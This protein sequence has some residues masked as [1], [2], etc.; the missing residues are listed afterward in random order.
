MDYKSYKNHSDIVSTLEIRREN[1]VEILQLYVLL[2]NIDK[3]TFMKYDFQY[4]NFAYSFTVDGHDIIEDDLSF[5]QNRY[6]IILKDRDIIF[7]KIVF[8]KR[9]WYRKI[10]KDL[11]KKANLNLRRI[12]E[13][14]KD[15][16]YQNT[17]LNIFVVSDKSTLK[18]A[19]KLQSN[20]EILLHANIKVIEDIEKIKKTLYLKN[21]KNII[22]YAV[23]DEK[24][25]NETRHI[26]EEFNEFVIVIGPNDHALSLTCGK[27]LI[28]NYVCI[29]TFSPE[30]IKNMVINTKYKLLNKNKL[31]N[32]IIALSG[33]SGGVGTTTIAMNTADLLAINNPNKNILYVDLSTSKA[34]SNLF[35]S[36]NPVPSTS[37]IDLVNS[38]EFNIKKNLSRGL[39]KIREN[40]YSITGI[41]KH[42]D[43]DI[44]TQETFAKKIVEYLLKASE[45]F[46]YIVI[47][48][49]RADASALKS[50][51][52]DIANELWIIT[53][54]S[55]PDTSKLKTF[56]A[57][58][59]RA[60]LKDKINFIM[61]RIDS[62]NEISL[63]DFK[64]I[65]NISKDDEAEHYR[66]PNDYKTLGKCWNYCEL[67]SQIAKT[68]IFIKEL[69]NILIDKRYIKKTIE[70]KNN[71]KGF[72]SF[73][74]NEEGK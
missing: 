30:L 49:G 6:A 48:I 17:S 62:L 68:S 24:L 56:Y 66:I 36:Q 54:M 5:T 7:G 12:F 44:L 41:Q 58:L 71:K 25:I 46:N 14:E 4:N 51:I 61:N 35:L 53:E 63:S 9:I 18:F 70:V 42:I 50:T 60:G 31:N 45:Y 72:L 52:Y 55:L 28:E 73:L 67:A 32:K 26:I 1:L 43:I 69:N 2:S 27:L 57:L 64:A 13:I 33:I 19:N 10:I 29:E 47:D 16:V 74:T 3:L 59:K 65:M 40:F 20:L 15:L 22:V 39:V 38:N 34:I 37:I 23:Q 11:L 21:A 8:N